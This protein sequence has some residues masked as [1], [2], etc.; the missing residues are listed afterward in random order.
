MR[1]LVITA[2]GLYQRH[3]S[4]RKG[5]R[6][7]YGH[8]TGHASCSHLGYRAV[9]RYGAWKGLTV[10]R[11]RL[12]LCGVAHQRHHVVPTATLGLQRGVIDIDCDVGDATGCCDVASCEWPQS[13][14]KS[15]DQLKYVHIPPKRRPK[16]R[17]VP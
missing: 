6:C 17:L 13:R 16:S 15:G 8:H 12:F 2:I 10:L 5:Y 14:R 9:R 4:P 7:A 3:L 11:G 1:Y